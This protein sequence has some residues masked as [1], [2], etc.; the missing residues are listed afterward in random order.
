MFTR[1]T[2][3]IE[4][5]LYKNGLMKIAGLDEAGRGAW[6]GPVVA[7]A[8]ILPP[9]LG[10]KG[11]NDSKLLSPEQREKLYLIIVKNAIAVGT[12]IISEKLID[13]AGII[14][15]TRQAFLA[16]ITGIKEQPDYLLIDGI[17]IFDHHLPSEFLIKGDRRAASIA[18]ASIV[19]KVTRDH[20]LIKYHRE[21]PDYGFDQHKGYGTPAHRKMIYT[22]GFC[23]LHRM[24]FKPLV[25]YNHWANEDE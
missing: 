8:V 21:Y 11:L 3:K 16:A 10:I 23:P 5:Q 25:D 9:R 13:S 7:A 20:L 2:Y 18:A 22:H 17:K 12:G 4:N 6:A 19:A 14:N 1:P 24:S 15:A